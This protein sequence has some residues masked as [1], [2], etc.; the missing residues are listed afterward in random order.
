[1]AAGAALLAR[2]VS[3]PALAAAF[4]LLAVG[5]VLMVWLGHYCGRCGERLL[6]RLLRL[7]VLPAA[8]LTALA[9][10]SAQ[11]LRQLVAFA[12]FGL[13]IVAFGLAWRRVSDAGRGPGA[14]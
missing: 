3:K 7:V 2:A 10:R 11:G 5:V 1:M 14:V 9:A 12:L 13:S 4:A 8:L 6:P